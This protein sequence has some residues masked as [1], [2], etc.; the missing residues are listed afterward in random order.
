MCVCDD[1]CV[2]YVCGTC[3]YVMCVCSVCMV[4]RVC[5]DVCVVRVCVMMCV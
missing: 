3:V 4:V 5:D 2:V 1:V